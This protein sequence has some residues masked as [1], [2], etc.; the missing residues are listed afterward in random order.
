MELPATSGLT[1]QPDSAAGAA[2]AAASTRPA[3]AS[4]V[5][6][7]YLA[8]L[9]LPAEARAT[10]QR[11]AGIAPS[12]D[13]AA[14]LAKLHHAL[15]KLDAAQ[16]TS[17]EAR[18]P[19]YASIGSRLDAAYG[20]ARTTTAPEPV[21]PLEHDSEGRIHLDTGPE[22]ARRSMVPWP[23]VLGPIWRARRAIGRLFTGG[24]APVPYEAP[25]SPDP[26]GIWRFVGARRRLTL[27]ALMIA[28]IG[29]AHV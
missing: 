25:D 7:R 16:T 18:A 8:A 22:P 13:D 15:A 21:P 1:A 27:L 19:A 20:A 24:K 23:W 6:E 12:D 9:P 2:G 28:Q 26:K 11:E 10:L 5:A 3:T 14:A 4:S 17:L 29:R